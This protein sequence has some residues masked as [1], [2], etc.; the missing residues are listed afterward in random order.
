MLAQ[1]YMF[2]TVHDIQYVLGRFLHAESHPH[3]SHEVTRSKT[4]THIHNTY[5][6]LLGLKTTTF[7]LAYSK[8]GMI[9]IDGSGLVKVEVSTDRFYLPK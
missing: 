8:Y 4:Y 9:L 1:I 3:T 5:C 6:M 2:G 7:Y